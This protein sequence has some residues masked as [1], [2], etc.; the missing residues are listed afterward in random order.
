[1]Q[2][3]SEA[4]YSTRPWKVY[5]EGPNA[6]KSGSFQGNSISK[7]G[8]KDIRFTRNKANTVVYAIVLGWPTKPVIVQSL[9]TSA[10]NVPAIANVQLIGT[11]EKLAWKQTP[12]GLRVE[13]PK[14]YQP[15]TDFT[16]A[17]KV[18]LT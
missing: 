18:S 6:V 14:R 17:L 3:N 5:G 16:A 7:L 8:V 1:M 9:G 11:D 15:K 2:V 10:A 12:E 4:I 13:L